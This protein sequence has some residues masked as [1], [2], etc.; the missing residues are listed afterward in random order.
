MLKSARRMQREERLQKAER[1][2]ERNRVSRLAAQL[3]AIIEVAFH[4]MATDRFVRFKVWGD[5]A[6]DCLSRARRALD[7]ARRFGSR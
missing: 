4:R 1:V 5:R 7:E 2:R 3:N 6:I